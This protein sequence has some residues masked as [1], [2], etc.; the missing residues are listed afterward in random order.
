[1]HAPDTEFMR[2]YRGIEGILTVSRMSIRQLLEENTGMERV[3]WQAVE[4]M[5]GHEAWDDSD[6]RAHVLCLYVR[7]IEAQHMREAYAVE[8]V[9]WLREHPEAAERLPVI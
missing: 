9:R 3:V 4:G 5:S 1:M 6:Y 7:T 8:R 2:I